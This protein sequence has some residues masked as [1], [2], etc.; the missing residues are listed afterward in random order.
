MRKVIKSVLRNLFIGTGFILLWPF[1]LLAKM[2]D[3]FPLSS[4]F[5]VFGAQ[6]VALFPGFPGN[7]MR[8]AYYMMTLEYFHPTA[9]IAFGSYISSRKTRIGRDVKIG[10]YCVIGLSDIQPSARIASRVSILSGIEEHGTSEDFMKDNLKKD[11]AQRVI[12]GSKAWV[13]EGAVVA[14]DVGEHSIVGAGSVLLNPL[15]SYSV[16]MAYPARQIPVRTK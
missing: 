11:G 14:A 3:R 6:M 5:Y 13:G 15:P 12:I 10:A 4:I 16:A 8:A 2:E 9:I 7:F 1:G